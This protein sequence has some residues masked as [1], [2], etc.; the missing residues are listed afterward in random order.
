MSK[1]IITE[2]HLTDFEQYLR[3]EEKSNATIRKYLC[4]VRRWMGFLAGKEVDKEK[5]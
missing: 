5:C 4:D 1:K 3:C 2:Q